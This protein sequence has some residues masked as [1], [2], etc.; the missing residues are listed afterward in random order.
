MHGK[1]IYLIFL[2]VSHHLEPLSSAQSLIDLSLG[3][4][5]FRSAVGSQL[6]GLLGGGLDLLVQL[7]ELLGQQ[8][9]EITQVSSCPLV[10]GVCQHKN[11]SNY[12]ENRNLLLLK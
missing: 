10:V 3:E 8:A 9:L 5:V 11:N 6:D 12:S 4:M 2:F 7:T 1:I